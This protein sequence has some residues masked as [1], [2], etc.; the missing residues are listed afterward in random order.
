MIRVAI[1]E[2]EDEFVA[3]LSAYLKRIETENDLQFSVTRFRD[4]EEL[5]DGYRSEYDLILM[6]IQMRNMDGMSAAELIRVKDSRVI[7]IF[8][9]N[10]ADYAIRGYQVDA[11]DYILKPIN[12]LSFSQKLQRAVER[13]ENRQEHRISINTK[14]GLLMINVS[15]VYYVESQGHKVIWHT[16]L[17][18]YEVRDR[19]RDIEQILLPYDFFRSNKGYLVNLQYVDGIQNECCLVRGNKLLIS[20]ARRSEFMAA[21]TKYMGEKG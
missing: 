7:I 13:I 12:Y 11:L 21:L 20:R 18:D 3:E 9:T 8:I 19:M 5:T 17:G 1:V 10:R 14:N 15:G 2:D 6:D 16:E 4:G